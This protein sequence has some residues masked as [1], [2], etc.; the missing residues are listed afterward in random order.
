MSVALHWWLCLVAVTFRCVGAVFSSFVPALLPS[1]MPQIYFVTI[2]DTDLSNLFDVMVVDPSTTG[3][4]HIKVG[5]GSASSAASVED[6]SLQTKHREDTQRLMERIT[7][8]QSLSKYETGATIDAM[9]PEDGHCLFHAL[10][11]GHIFPQQSER[12]DD[13]S[14]SMRQW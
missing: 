13:S 7:L 3:L 11:R 6:L 5:T 1:G 10:G 9:T 2:D 4:S 14:K 12:P 8:Q